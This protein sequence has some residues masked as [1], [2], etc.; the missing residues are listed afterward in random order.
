MHG[1]EYEHSPPLKNYKAIGFLKN[2]GPNPLKN[3]KAIP[4]KIHTQV[5]REAIDD[6]NDDD[7]DDDDDDGPS[8]ARQR[9]ASLAG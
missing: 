1:W 5:R 3:H 2:T 4:A 7:D 6:D 8:S 9:N